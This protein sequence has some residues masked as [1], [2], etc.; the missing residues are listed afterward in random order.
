VAE[1]TPGGW[2]LYHLD[3]SLH[4]IRDGSGKLESVSDEVIVFRDGDT[5]RTERLDGKVVGS[6]RVKPKCTVQLA[7][8]DKLFV[9][10]CKRPG[11]VD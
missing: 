1:T 9:S 6:L 7:G 10:N 11:V 3:S 4:P 5:I 8:R 2:K